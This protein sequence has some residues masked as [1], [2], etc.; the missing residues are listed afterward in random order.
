MTRH[1]CGR[2]ALCALALMVCTQRAWSEGYY[3]VRG[4]SCRLVDGATVVTQTPTAFTAW[5]SCNI[6]DIVT[7]LY[8]NATVVAPSFAGQLTVYRTGGSYS[9][10]STVRFVAGDV[11]GNATLVTLS[12]AGQFSIYVDGP[13]G[14]TATVS[15]DVFGAFV[16]DL[17]GFRPFHAVSGCRLL[18]TRVDPLGALTHLAPRDVQ[19]GGKCGVPPDAAAVTATLT[20]V[21]ATATGHLRLYYPGAEV[22][23]T[24]ALNFPDSTVAMARAN[25]VLARL[26]GRT[27]AELTIRANLA[28]G[29]DSVHV[30]LDVTGYYGH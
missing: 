16:P 2:I 29:G 13:P 19:V 1:G 21:Q 4:A 24:T 11:I 28:G 30:V 15:V 18:D 12:P 14:Q 20:A 22:P 9:S 5:G 25:G 6:P 10:L 27:G 8:V 23:G 17:Y 26:F 3:A 7:A